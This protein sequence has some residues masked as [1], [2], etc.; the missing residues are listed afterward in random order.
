MNKLENKYAEFKFANEEGTDELV[1]KGYPAIFETE[2]ALNPSLHPEL[3][4]YVLAKDIIHTGAFTKTLLERKDRIAFCRNHDRMNPIAKII[5]L[6]EDAT[7]LLVEAR[8]SD[9]EVETKMKIREEILSEMSIGYI[10]TKA[11]MEQKN[12]GTW[13]RHIYEVKLYECS[14]VTESRHAD[15]KIT[16]KKNLEDALTLVDKLIINEK[17]E[18][19]KYSLLQLKSLIDDEPGQPLETEKPI[20]DK[21]SMFANFVFE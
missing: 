4:K 16:E 11:Q 8:I 21:K 14:I 19:K 13:I 12:D 2:D 15:T 10:V 7:G 5:E 18:E 6:K 3:K 1:I 9:S 20:E 17:N